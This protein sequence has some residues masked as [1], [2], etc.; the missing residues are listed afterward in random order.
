M[1]RPPRAARRS[2]TRFGSCRRH[3]ALRSRR[4]TPTAAKST[5]WSTKSTTP[6]LRGPSW[7]GGAGR[8]PAPLVATPNTQPSSGIVSLEK[9]GM[10]P[11]TPRNCPWR[12]FSTKTRRREGFPENHGVLALHVG[13][14][15]R[16]LGVPPAAN[17]GEGIGLLVDNC[18]QSTLR[19]IVADGLGKTETLHQQSY[20]ARLIDSAGTLEDF[21]AF[22]P[23]TVASAYEL[24]GVR[25]IGPEATWDLRRLRVSGQPANVQ[26]YYSGYVLAG[27]DRPAGRTRSTSAR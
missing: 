15:R 23:T 25:V 8:S 11:P 20:G 27:A 26:N 3:S 21:T 22:F 1:T 18:K 12:I 4:S 19:R 16:A 6:A 2:I 17:T 9:R 13:E 24:T 10:F 14:N 7:P 5:M